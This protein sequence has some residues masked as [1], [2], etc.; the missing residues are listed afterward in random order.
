MATSSWNELSESP[1]YHEHMLLGALFEDDE[2]LLATPL[3]YGHPANEGDAFGEGCALSDLTGMTAILVSGEGSDA[4]VSAACACSA[5]AVGECTFGAVVTGDGSIASV[6]LV[7]RTGDAEYLI[8]DPSTRGMMLHPWLN[9]LS[10]IEQEGF[11]P[12]GS[13]T[14]ED[15]TDSLV[16]LLLWGAQAPAILS[17][18]V[19]SIEAL[20]H[21]GHIRDVRLDKIECLV[22]SLPHV[23]EPCLLVMVPPAYARILWRSF[24]SFAS[25]EPVGT[26]ALTN[27]AKDNLP[28][29]DA[30]LAG[31]RLELE[32]EQLVAWELARSEG[33]FVGARALQV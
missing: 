15:A 33:G 28:W 26:A 7:A 11:R 9:F 14:V 32:L 3:H 4:F 12:F 24:L 17:D 21:P 1:L 25:V 10:E 30:V 18:Y 31:E 23:S 29:A 2:P 6:P 27:Q 13:V 5:I 19:S 16:P 20:P 22:A 8:W